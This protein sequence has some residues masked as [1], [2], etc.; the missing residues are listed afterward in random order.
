[1]T[2]FE[3]I[4][5][6]SVAL[7]SGEILK[8]QYL[9]ACSSKLIDWESVRS[10]VELLNGA[11]A[12]EVARLFVQL[13]GSD[14]AEKAIVR[15]LDVVPVP[16]TEDRSS[17]EPEVHAYMVMPC[18]G[19]NRMFEAGRFRV[20]VDAYE[21]DAAQERFTRALA[22]AAAEILARMS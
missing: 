21:D 1:M 6:C 8:T 16:P 22:K 9:T 5:A 12:F 11:D 18:G 15:A 17:V 10:G 20:L 4:W 19:R 2:E 3:L 14:L 13:A 7:L